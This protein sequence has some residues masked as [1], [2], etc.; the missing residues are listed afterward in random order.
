MPIRPGK[1]RH[2]H[3]IRPFAHLLSSQIV[4]S[5]GQPIGERPNLAPAA[6]ASISKTSSL[7]NQRDY[8]NRCRCHCLDHDGNV[9]YVHLCQH[10]NMVPLGLSVRVWH[11]PHFPVATDVDHCWTILRRFV[12]VVRVGSLVGKR[13][14]E[15][16]GRQCFISDKPAP[17]PSWISTLWECRSTV[18]PSLMAPDKGRNKLEKT[19]VVVVVWYRSNGSCGR[20]YCC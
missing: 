18:G 17:R 16:F 7:T 13:G 11:H 19:C 5:P 3:H 6:H 10:H 12:I 9:V 1:T 2:C 8:W 4:A 15:R 14:R 20:G